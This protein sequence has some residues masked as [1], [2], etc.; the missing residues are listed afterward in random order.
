MAN[1]EVAVT[2]YDDDMQWTVTAVPSSIAEASPM[3][4]FGGDLDGD[5][6][7]GR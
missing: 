4:E 3:E 6:G 2:V 7:D 1:V 5:G